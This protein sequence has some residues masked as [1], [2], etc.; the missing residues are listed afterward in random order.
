M[1]ASAVFKYTVAITYGIF[2][3][4]ALGLITQGFILAATE[5]FRSKKDE[6]TSETETE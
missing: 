6:P 5:D 2:V 4:K 3:G 1:K